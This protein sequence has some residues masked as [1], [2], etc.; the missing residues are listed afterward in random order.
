MKF[1][2][3]TLLYLSTVSALS[4]LRKLPNSTPVARIVGGQLASPGQ[5]P[6]QVAIYKY[7][8]DG[9]YFCGGTLYNEQ[10]ILTKI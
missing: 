10:W 9:R 1:L 2:V 4:S 5:F 6:W 8:A 7:T 3:L